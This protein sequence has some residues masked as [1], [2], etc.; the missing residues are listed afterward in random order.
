MSLEVAVKR[1]R[2][3]ADL[4]H[5]EHVYLIKDLLPK[6]TGLPFSIERPSTPFSS[7]FISSSFLDEWEVRKVGTDR[8]LVLGC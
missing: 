2:G 1:S 3:F 6:R 5:C 8:G 4:S 7:A